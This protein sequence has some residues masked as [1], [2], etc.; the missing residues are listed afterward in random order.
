MPSAQASHRI[1]RRPLHAMRGR[2]RFFPRPLLGMLNKPDRAQ[3]FERLRCQSVRSSCRPFGNVSQLLEQL[4]GLE[5]RELKIMETKAYRPI[6]ETLSA[7][8]APA[9]RTLRRCW[10]PRQALFSMTNDAESLRQPLG[11]SRARMSCPPR[12][13]RHQ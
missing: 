5:L 12:V 1:K 8:R 13:E 3:V 10:C 4:L 7:N 6:V 2:P 9:R 11:I